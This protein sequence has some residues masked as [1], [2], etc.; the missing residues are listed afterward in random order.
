MPHSSTR[1]QDARNGAVLL[2]LLTL[3]LT[4]LASQIGC[5]LGYCIADEVPLRRF[6]KD[7]CSILE[8]AAVP[9]QLYDS[10]E[11]FQDWPQVLIS[12]L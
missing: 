1:L 2:L 12:I 6:V 9:G 5:M 8:A 10:L 7:F 3:T 4:A 11:Y